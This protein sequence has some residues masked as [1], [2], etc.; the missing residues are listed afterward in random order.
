MSNVMRH[1]YKNSRMT[2]VALALEKLK[3][4]EP[5]V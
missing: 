4:T 3:A 5:N 1:R 2:F